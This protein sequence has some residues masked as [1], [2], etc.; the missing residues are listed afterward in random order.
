MHVCRFNLRVL[1]CRIAAMLLAHLLPAPL[2]TAGA[3]AQ[4]LV[5]QQV[6]ILKQVEQQLL[7][8]AAAN[9][10]SSGAVPAGLLV[11]AVQQLL[12]EATY[13][14]QQVR[15]FGR[16]ASPGCQAQASLSWLAVGNGNDSTSCTNV[17]GQ[18]P[19]LCSLLL[20]HGMGPSTRAVIKQQWAVSGN[21][22]VSRRQLY[23]VTRDLCC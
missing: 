18:Q 17:C 10:N 13:T 8:Y 7:Q 22:Q 20:A 6:T 16:R 23:S 15:D 9:S 19:H 2:G 3:P 5:W 4:A 12:P 21:S 14:L 1:E 11:W